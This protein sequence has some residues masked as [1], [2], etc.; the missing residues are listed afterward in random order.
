V[1]DSAEES[2]EEWRGAVGASASGAALAACPEPLISVLLDS[3]LRTGPN[4]NLVDGYEPRELV[5]EL[6]RMRQRARALAW[7]AGFSA[8]DVYDYTPDYHAFQGWYG[9]RHDGVPSDFGDIVATIISNWGPLEHPDAGSFYACSPHRIQVAAI[10]LRDQYAPELAN[11]M[12]AVLP[13]WVEW[14]LSRVSLDEAFAALSRA[15]VR[16]EAAALA[17][18]DAPRAEPEDE[19]PFRRQE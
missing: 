6:Y 4:A 7:R 14:C 1:F 5:R 8:G 13:E 17:S 10:L 19:G 11:E 18:D 15:A 3:C 12:L 2:L 9:G 16:A